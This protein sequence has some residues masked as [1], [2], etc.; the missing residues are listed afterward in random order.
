MV[1]G[2]G[3]INTMGVQTD[4]SGSTAK[5]VIDITPRDFDFTDSDAATFLVR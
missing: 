5:T 2:P 4:L 1:L 3:L